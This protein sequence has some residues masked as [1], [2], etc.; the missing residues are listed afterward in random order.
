VFGYGDAAFEKGHF[1]GQ[2]ATM[3][4]SEKDV[5]FTVSKDGKS[6]YVYFLGMPAPESKLEIK[7]TGTAAIRRVV[8]VGSGKE[9]K[10]TASDNGVTVSTPAFADMDALATVLKI[11]FE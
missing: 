5:R 4:Y 1:G 10:W 3:K 11:E 2:S 7:N 8:V 9:L 6:L